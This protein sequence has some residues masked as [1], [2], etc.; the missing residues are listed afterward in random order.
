MCRR[1][2]IRL[3]LPRFENP[4][5]FFSPTFASLK[6][7]LHAVRTLLQQL[8]HGTLVLLQLLLLLQQSL[9]WLKALLLAFCLNGWA[10]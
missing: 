10:N 7:Q 1:F 3:R 9:C 2:T 8:P 6:G 5:Q 4:H